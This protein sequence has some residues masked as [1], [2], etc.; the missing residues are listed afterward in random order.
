[1]SKSV[2]KFFGAR[3]VL[4]V[5][6]ACQAFTLATMLASII[7]SLFGTLAIEKMVEHIS[8]CLVAVILLHAPLLVRSKFRWRIPA[9]F[10]ILVTVFIVTHFVLGEI[11]R[12]YDYVFLFDKVLHTTAGVALTLGG[13]S[14][15]Y[16][17][18]KAEDGTVRLSPFFVGLFSFCFA[19]MLLSLWEIFEFS[20]DTTF[21]LN[22]QRWQDGLSEIAVDGTKKLITDS[23]Q[24]S[25]LLDTMTDLIVGVVGAAVISV[26]GGLWVKKNPH[27]TSFFIVID[28]DKK[29]ISCTQLKH[30][31]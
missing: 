16:A 28:K 10:Q 24:G 18:S 25:G 22:M 23:A 6:I 1:M 8:I 26:L 30:K 11:Y 7:T 12:F 19:V 21:G 5:Y 27:N 17:F 4:A 31:T 3:K 20:M 15:V 13:F 2:S 9:F 14:I 29:E